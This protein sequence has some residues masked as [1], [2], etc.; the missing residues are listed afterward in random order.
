MTAAGSV[1]HAH[2]PTAERLRLAKATD[3]ARWCYARGLGP[4]VSNE[5]AATR[6]AIA[7]QAGV[8]PPRDIDGTSET[9]ALVA[10]LL[11]DRVRW[12]LAHGWQPPPPPTCTGCLVHGRPCRRHAPPSDCTACGELLH[13]M[14]VEAGERLHPNCAPPS[15]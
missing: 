2:T 5:G 15:W 7:R 10:S 8:R 11:R 4:D 1:D 9:W 12:D 3:L 6:R 13:P 14:L